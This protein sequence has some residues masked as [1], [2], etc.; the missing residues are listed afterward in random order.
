MLPKIDNTVPPPA[1][2]S[3]R[4]RV[5]SNVPAPSTIRYRDL[6][7]RMSPGDSFEVVGE[8]ERYRARSIFYWYVRDTDRFPPG[9]RIVTRLLDRAPRHDKSQARYRIW[10]TAP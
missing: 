10:I 6:F 1:A 8:V 7:D 3:R 9:T 5:T 4:V 2:S